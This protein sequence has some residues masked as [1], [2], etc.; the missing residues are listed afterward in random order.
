MDIASKLQLFD[1]VIVPIM[2]YGCEIWGFNNI[3]DIEKI[4][5][6]F[7]RIYLV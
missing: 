5:I 2:L 1:T 4:Q 7:I 6:R 3:S